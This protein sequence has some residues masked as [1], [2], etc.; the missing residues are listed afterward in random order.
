M[1]VREHLPSPKLDI[2]VAIYLTGRRLEL[3]PSHNTWNALSPV[4]LHTQQPQKPGQAR[5][6]SVAHTYSLRVAARK[7]HLVHPGKRLRRGLSQQPPVMREGTLLQVG[8]LSVRKANLQGSETNKGTT[9][10]PGQRSPGTGGGNSQTH[11]NVSAHSTPTG[12]R[13]VNPAAGQ[14]L[15]T[16]ML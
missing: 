2:C 5:H 15:R 1:C 14:M 4:H 9:R 12:F 3:P 13:Q 7:V 8:L 16:R 6:P 11:A 10:T